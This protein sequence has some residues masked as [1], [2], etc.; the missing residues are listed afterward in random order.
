MWINKN[1]YIIHIYIYVYAILVLYQ[2][3]CSILFVF[4]TNMQNCCH[5]KI[6]TPKRHSK[7]N[8]IKNMT[9]KF[10]KHLVFPF[11][12]PLSGS[13]P[14]L[15]FAQGVPPCTAHGTP[16]QHRPLGKVALSAI[17]ASIRPECDVNSNSAHVYTNKGYQY[18]HV[19]KLYIYI[20]T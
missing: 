9:S 7:W 2:C 15:T 5:G 11:C 10:R 19:Y 20:Y 1:I 12:P 13:V 8:F 17:C 4:Q 18:M 16:A 14:C 6:F 3:R